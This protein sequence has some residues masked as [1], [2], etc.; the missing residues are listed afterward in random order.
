MALHADRQSHRP[1]GARCVGLPST[2]QRCSGKGEVVGVV[3]KEEGGAHAPCAK[4]EPLRRARL[5]YALSM[6]RWMPRVAPRPE[7][8]VPG[9]ASAPLRHPTPPLCRCART[10]RVHA[11]AA[12]RIVPARALRLPPLTVPLPLTPRGFS[13]GH[14][15]S[16][17][18]WAW[19]SAWVRRGSDGTAPVSADTP[20]ACKLPP[21]RYRSASPQRCWQH[22]APCAVGG[23]TP[24]GLTTPFAT[25][26]YRLRQGAAPPPGG[27]QRGW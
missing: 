13:C 18:R 3:G 14:G 21:G 23:P 2:V 26:G 9:R 12:D 11:A 1:D 19:V 25:C 20:H 16:E 10:T 7:H 22:P 15:D 17:R 4:K 27:V 24:S 5:L 6:A 8:S